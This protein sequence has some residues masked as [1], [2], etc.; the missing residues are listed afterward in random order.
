MSTTNNLDEFA[1]QELKE[2]EDLYNE[3]LELHLLNEEDTNLEDML[4]SE[5]NLTTKSIFALKKLIKQLPNGEIRPHQLIL[6]ARISK[7]IESK[8]DSLMQAGTGVGKSISYLIPAIISGRK[9][10]VSTSTKQLTSQLT[11]K[12]LPLLK[13]YLFPNLEFSGLQSLTNYICPKRLTD[14][15]EE[16]ELDE[17]LFKNT[18]GDDY[19][20][21][22][23]VIP[24]YQE[25][26]K[27]NMN[28]EEFTIESLGC[29]CESFQCAGSSCVRGCKFKGKPYCPVNRIVNQVLKSDVV[30]TNHAYVSRMLVTTSKNK[31]KE[32]G[33]LKGRN[34]WI[35]DEAHDLEGYAERAFSTELH[36]GTLKFVYLPKLERYVTSNVMEDT[37]RNRYIEYDKILKSQNV[38]L[39]D[40]MRYWDASELTTDV[41][42]V[43]LI[44]GNIL[45][46]LDKYKFE[47]DLKLD[48]LNEGKTKFL[49]ESDE[50][51]LT[52]RDDDIEE[53]KRLIDRLNAIKAKLETISITGIEV[54]YV[55]TFKN[56]VSELAESLI[57]LYNAHSNSNAYVTY[58]NIAKPRNDYDDPFK[59]SATYL[60]T[61]DAIQAGLGYL[62]IDKSDLNTVN[63]TKIN[64][65]GVSATLCVDGSFR[66][67]AD[68]LGMTKLKDIHCTCEDV[69][70]V[71]DYQKQGLMYIP[72]GI[73]DVKN[74][75]KEH[76]EYFKSSIK[77]LIEISDGGALVLCTTKDETQR[78][79]AFLDYEFKGR[80]RVL[81]AEDKEKWKSKN[82][83]VK[84]FRED[85]NSILVGTRGFFQGLDVQGDS[86]RLLCL[87]K[88]P[89][90]SPRCC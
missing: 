36:A 90:G 81:S 74:N 26:L 86:L 38:E 82:D 50:D 11:E 43:G 22:K 80:F 57:T 71:F 25:Y 28:P 68:K 70:T 73:P 37:F 84:A 41:R 4:S 54:K 62:D 35:C 27:S 88:L 58:Y 23:E 61:G 39:D 13:K 19:K 8:D 66:D 5:C 67:T 60:Q 53:M 32:L 77:K 69:G 16:A 33:I 17:N 79:A 65:I 63:S 29:N 6:I 78:T 21:I 49:I 34:L 44:I 46:M 30:V 14:L 52:F 45:R 31:E 72:V 59:I 12:D 15:M 40:D 42:A 83:L 47:A 1:I 2:I 10:F 9:C 76:F 3:D 18:R 7:S 64:M 87:N 48:S 56:I 24:K 89:F 55:P 20:A 75:R 85:E 51:F